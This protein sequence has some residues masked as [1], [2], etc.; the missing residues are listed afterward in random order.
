[1]VQSAPVEPRSPSKADKP[2]YYE[3]LPEAIKDVPV[4]RNYHFKLTPDK[5]ANWHSYGHFVSLFYNSL[6]MFFPAGETMFIKSVQAHRYATQT[7]P[8]L[9][10]QVSAFVA[11]EAIHGREHQ[12]YNDA[13]RQV[14]PWVTYAERGAAW[15]CYMVLTYL[16]IRMQLAA[17]VSLEHWTGIL[18]GNA[19]ENLDNFNGS[20]E[21]FKMI[22]HWHAL[23]E[24][25]HKAVA[26]DVY[27]AVYGYGGLAYIDK[28]IAIWLSS[29]LLWTMAGFSF[30]CQAV[31]DL[32]IFNPIEWINLFSFLW[33]YP[34]HMR[35]VFRDYWEF[36]DPKFHPW[37]HDNRYTMKDM[38]EIQEKME[39]TTF[40]AK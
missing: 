19:L 35:G 16:P 36:F 3:L 27:S 13:I 33:I 26:F 2:L 6:S 22:W 24:N 34:G 11:Q 10:K 4:K 32:S 23:E 14:Y 40:S 5:V 17:T 25:E 18:A 28:F 21:A 38:A 8:L 7:D 37:R 30:L 12:I 15:L 31:Y 29:I 39:G 1:M 20:E 9:S